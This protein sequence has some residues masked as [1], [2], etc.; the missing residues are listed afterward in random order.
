MDTEAEK[1]IG[2]AH[3][4]SEQTQISKTIPRARKVKL[5]NY[6]SDYISKFQVY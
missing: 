4:V 6:F 2:Q 1:E 5:K 3:E